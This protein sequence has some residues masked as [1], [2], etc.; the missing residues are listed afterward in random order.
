VLYYHSTGGARKKYVLQRNRTICLTAA[1][2]AISA[3]NQQNGS[4]HTPG[5]DALCVSQQMTAVIEAQ[6]QITDVDALCAACE[7]LRD[8]GV[9][10][11]GETA[12]AYVPVYTT[13][14][15]NCV[16]VYICSYS[17][18]YFHSS[19]YQQFVLYQKKKLG[20]P[21]V[22]SNMGFPG[23]GCVPS[24][25]VFQGVGGVA[26]NPMFPSVSAVVSGVGVSGSLVGG[27]EKGSRVTKTYETCFQAGQ[28][29]YVHSGTGMQRHDMH[30][31]LLSEFNAFEMGASMCR[32]DVETAIVQFQEANHDNS[33]LLSSPRMGGG[34]QQ[35]KDSKKS[36]VVMEFVHSSLAIVAEKEKEEDNSCSLAR[37]LLRGVHTCD[38]RSDVKFCAP[39]HIFIIAE[40]KPRKKKQ[41]WTDWVF[42][43]VGVSKDESV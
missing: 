35:K 36:V 26:C 10:L 9:L 5:V 18:S 14:S 16:T 24:H 3:V 22:A 27:L 39:L 23:V 32:K 12:H 1:L 20:Q 31:T 8:R 15:H 17:L 25:A 29:I 2:C 19:F 42:V 11:G 41:E 30:V 21:A 6:M 28:K 38:G 33:A 37:A 43:N 34:G 40:N 4:T 7:H 13:S